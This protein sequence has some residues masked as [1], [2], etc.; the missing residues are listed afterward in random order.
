MTNYQP[1]QRWAGPAALF[2]AVYWLAMFTGTHTPIEHFE[3]NFNHADKLLHFSAYGGLAFLLALN[4]LLRRRTGW[5]VYLAALLIA[6]CFGAFDEL[7]QPLAGRDCELL[8]WVADTCGAAAGLCALAWLRAFLR[9]RD[10]S[11]A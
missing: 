1:Q 10:P 4:F 6:C 9:R 8:D 11:L 3:N 7:T 2:L 5:P